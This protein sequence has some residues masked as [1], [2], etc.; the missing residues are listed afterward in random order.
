MLSGCWDLTTNLFITSPDRVRRTNV[1]TLRL[2]FDGR[3][4]GA[5][6]AVLEDNRRCTGPLSARFGPEET[7]VVDDEAPCRGPDLSVGRSGRMCRRIGDTEAVCTGHGLD[8]SNMTYEG[9][10]RRSAS[11]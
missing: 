4:H 3:G 8:G 5:Q 7:L 2:C 1:R 6:S 9:R 10:F 11:Q